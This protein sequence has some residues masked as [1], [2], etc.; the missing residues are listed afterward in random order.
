M[1]VFLIILS[2][3]LAIVDRA[4]EEINDMLAEE[5]E[6]ASVMKAIGRRG[7]AFFTS[8]A[9]GK[10]LL[11]LLSAHEKIDGVAEAIG[12]ADKDGDGQLTKIGLFWILF[13]FFFWG[14]FRGLVL[15]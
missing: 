9:T 14:G 6:K 2:M 1:I 5:I 11:H 13:W 8:S 7:H 12:K 3:L 15:V 10:K 4:Y